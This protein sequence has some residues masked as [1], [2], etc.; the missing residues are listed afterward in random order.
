[1]A[2]AFTAADRQDPRL[3]RDGKLVFVL[4][5]QTK[6]YNN[7]DPAKSPQQSIPIS[8]LNYI[9]YTVITHV[10]KATAEL[11]IG[12]FFFTLRSCE[13]CTVDGDR[14]TKLLSIKHISF[15]KNNKLLNMYD[16]YIHEADCMK[17]IF[18]THKNG[19]KN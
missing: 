14:K 8:I 9:Y 4:Q 10:E 13:C 1:L 12:A 17:I 15:Y 5:R 11:L 2:Q 7:L 6:G 19:L 3:A 18:K 16:N